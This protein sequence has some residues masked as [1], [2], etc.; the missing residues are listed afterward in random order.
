MDALRA[1]IRE[2]AGGALDDS[3]SLIREDRER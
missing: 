1:R 2:H 3:V